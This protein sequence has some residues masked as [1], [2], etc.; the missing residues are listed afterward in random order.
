MG[1]SM[2]EGQKSRSRSQRG[3]ATP[4]VLVALASTAAACSNAGGGTV[5]KTVHPAGPC[6][7]FVTTVRTNESS[8]APGQ[9]VIIS[10]TQANEGPTCHGIPPAWC[11]KLQAFASAYNSDGEDVWDYGASKSIPGHITCLVAPA[12]GP[13]WP[14]HYS[15]TQKLDWSQDK[16]L[17][18]ETGQPGHANPNCPGTHVPA[19]TYRIVGNGTSASATITISS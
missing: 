2:S 14:A 17:R 16:C 12:P 8:Y 3:W 15:N 9:T 5:S 7:H 6:E 4:L 10:V 19:G 11:G 18:D 13:R 1:A